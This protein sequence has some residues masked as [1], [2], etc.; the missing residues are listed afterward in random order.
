MAVTIRLSYQLIKCNKL[1]NIRKYFLHPHKT[2]INCKK[3]KCHQ[4]I[5]KKQ[6]LDE[7]IMIILY[8]FTRINLQDQREKITVSTNQLRL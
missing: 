2:H 3:I 7:Q 5:K 1:K 4:I 6:S 8:A